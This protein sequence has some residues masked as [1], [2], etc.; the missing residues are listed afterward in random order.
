MGVGEGNLA[1]IRFTDST[2]QT[3]Q[4]D[5]ERMTWKGWRWVTFPLDGSG[6]GRWGGANDGFV[7]HPIRLDTLFLVD[8][9]DQ[10]KP[11]RGEVWISSPV[12]AY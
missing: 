4:P 12:L 11:A 9:P 3:F 2:G 8:N 1:R 10:S 7:H 6:S 5:G